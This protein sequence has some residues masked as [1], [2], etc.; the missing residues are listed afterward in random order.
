MKIVSELFASYFKIYFHLSLLTNVAIKS[1]ITEYYPHLIIEFPKKRGRGRFTK[2][3]T[4]LRIYTA[5]LFV[6]DVIQ[7]SMFFI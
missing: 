3:L 6:Q 4:Y 5:N 7:P 2:D 1:L